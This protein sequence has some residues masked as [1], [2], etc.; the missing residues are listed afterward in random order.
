MNAPWGLMFLV[1]PFIDL[2]LMR[3][4]AGQFISL[5]LLNARLS[6]FGSMVADCDYSFD[7]LFSLHSM[8]W[9]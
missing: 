7:F 5:T 8:P 4:L 2:S 6:I 9:S 1:V 3:I